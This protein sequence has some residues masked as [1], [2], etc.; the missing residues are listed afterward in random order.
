MPPLETTLVRQG[1]KILDNKYLEKIL[2]TRDLCV[3]FTPAPISGSKRTEL[4]KLMLTNNL[5]FKHFRGTVAK[6]YLENSPFKHLS[7]IMRGPIM[8]AYPNE[9]N[10]FEQQQEQTT[11]ASYTTT[12][13]LKKI[14]KDYNF[15]LIGIKWKNQFLNANQV[16]QLKS[17]GIYRG[18]VLSLFMKYQRTLLRAFKIHLD[19]N[20]TNT[21]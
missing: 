21:N 8:I 20:E 3:F 1:K 5:R 17:E 13:F 19:K 9:L 4:T 14:E 2:T 16:H 18:E 10:Q 12:N 11:N 15:N 6:K 7:P